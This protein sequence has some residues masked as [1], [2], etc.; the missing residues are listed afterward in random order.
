MF[1][2]T[3]VYLLRIINLSYVF[4]TLPDFRQRVFLQFGQNR[5]FWPNAIIAIEQSIATV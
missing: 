3:V 1:P 2:L 5:F 4:D